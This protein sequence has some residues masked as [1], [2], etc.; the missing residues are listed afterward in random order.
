MIC[1]NYMFDDK[2]CIEDGLL[3][4]H[5]DV[6]D[7]NAQCRNKKYKPLLFPEGYAELVIKE[8]RS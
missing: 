6:P 8:L 2:T 3:C 5:D 4:G 7:D 1:T